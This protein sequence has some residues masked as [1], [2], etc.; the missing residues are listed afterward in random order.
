MLLLY[1]AVLFHL[2]YLNEQT[3]YI[4]G[5]H[6]MCVG[7]QDDSLSVDMA[8]TQNDI[9]KT[10]FTRLL[11]DVYEYVTF[12]VCRNSTRLI[13][14]IAELAL[15]ERFQV[16]PGKHDRHTKDEKLLFIIAHLDLRM[17]DLLGNLMVFARIPIV[18]LNNEYT[19]P[20]AHSDNIKYNILADTNAWA[21]RNLLQQV[22]F[23]R[24][25]YIAII[26]LN[27]SLTQTEIYRELHDNF[28][29][30]L[31]SDDNR[32]CFISVTVDIDSNDYDDVLARL[33][34]D[35]NLRTLMLFGRISHQVRDILRKESVCS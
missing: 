18:F 23:F 21:E 27:S 4:A 11:A 10:Y 28:L 29:R 16:G 12:D 9:I 33:R 22:N 3:T 5:I 17:S 31:N 1:I 13:E 30:L 14:T 24:W 26:L 6:S 32:I 35:R 34:D 19:I 15:S 8:I 25:K 7:K 20:G 2:V